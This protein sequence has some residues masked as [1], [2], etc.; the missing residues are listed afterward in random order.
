MLE[1]AAAEFP[2]FL[3]GLGTVLD[4]ET[5]RG[6]HPGRCEVHR[7]SALRPDVITMCRRY[8][9]PVFAGALTPTEILSAWRRAPT[10]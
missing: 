3:F 7:H 9:V 4:A 5:T 1:Q 6:G 8:R 10:P 2:D